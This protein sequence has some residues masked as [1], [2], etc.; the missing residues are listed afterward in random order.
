MRLTLIPCLLIG[1]V[2]FSGCPEAQSSKN[3]SKKEEN[4]KNIEANPALQKVGKFPRQVAESS[5]LA[6][7]TEANVFYTMGDAGNGPVIFK[8]KDTGE[9]L[10]RI[11]LPVG[12]RDWESLSED[13]NGNLYVADAGNNSNNRKDLVIYKLK[14]AAPSQVQSI[15][16]SYP[17]QQDFPPKKKERNFDSEASLWHNGGL[18]LFTRDRG[19]ER[20]SKVYL[21]P[22]EPGEYV[23]K[24]VAE[25]SVDGQ[26][27]GADISPDGKKLVLV[28][29]NK[30]FLFEGE[31]MTEILKA[32]PTE[33][34]IKGAG[35]TEGIL[36]TDNNKLLISSEEGNV[37]TY[38][39]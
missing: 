3:K 12:N 27:T 1:C 17:D 7:T 9:L 36:F 11:K 28:S 24:K 2:L 20:T 4:D 21:L 22:D 5:G 8:V 33:I 35:Q 29:G 18:Y 32:T 26:V 37:Y 16:F 30:F 38:T 6:R 25:L 39:L 14:P 13:T 19:R 10:D 23:A 34:S 15:K 31:N